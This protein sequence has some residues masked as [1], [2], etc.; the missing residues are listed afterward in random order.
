MRITYELRLASEPT[1]DELLPI[2]SQVIIMVCIPT[3]WRR[4][5][6]KYWRHQTPC[7]LY[8]MSGKKCNFIFDYNSSIP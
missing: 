2:T 5:D 3:K 7:T 8:T 6:C 4:N 1:Y